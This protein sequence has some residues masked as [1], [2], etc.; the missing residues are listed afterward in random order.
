MTRENLFYGLIGLLAGI[1]LTWVVAASSVNNQNFGMMRM[2]GMGRGVGMMGNYSGNNY[3]N[4][5][6]GVMMEGT[7]NNQ[8]GPMMDAMAGMMIDLN[9][10]TGN[11]FDQAFLNG[12]ILHHEGAIQMANAALKKAKH[13]E[14]KKLANDI[15]SAQ[16]KEI[17]QMKEWQ[18]TWYENK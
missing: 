13:E 10:K 15:I 2:M 17:S 7:E 18:K 8:K 5:S 16:T 4:G 11:E 14:I 6:Y 12:M 9:K 1:V 3:N